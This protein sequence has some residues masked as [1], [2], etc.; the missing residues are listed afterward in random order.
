MVKSNSSK[1]VTIKP[2]IKPTISLPGTFDG[3]FAPRTPIIKSPK[4]DIGK[5]FAPKTPSV[6][7][8]T[9]GESYAPRTISVKGSNNGGKK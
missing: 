6:K 2:G 3:G 4:T 5:G 9:R 1:T 7:T 8:P